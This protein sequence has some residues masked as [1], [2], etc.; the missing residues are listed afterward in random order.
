MSGEDTTPYYLETW[1]E[2]AFGLGCLAV[3][4]LIYQNLRPDWANIL[5][6][7][8]VEITSMAKLF[9]EGRMKDAF[10]NHNIPPVYPLLLAAI[11][12]IRHISELPRLLESLQILNLALCGISAALVHF[13]VRRQLPK[14]YNFII[15]GLYVLAPTTYDMAWPYTPHMTYMVMSMAALVAI[16]IS[17]SWDSVL[18]GQLSPREIAICGLFLVLSIL[19]WQ[20]GYLLLLAFMCVLLKRFGLK[21]SLQVTLGVMLCIAPFIARDLQAMSSDSERYTASTR[22]IIQ[23]V[24]E[25]GLVRTVGVYADHIMLK[26]ASTTIGDLN[27]SSLNLLGDSSHSA[28]A[29]EPSNY[30]EE[31]TWLRWV[32][33]LVAMVGAFYGFSYYTGVGAF[34][35]CIYVIASVALLPAS[36]LLLAPVIPLL[37]FYLYSGLLRTGAWMHR[38][39]LPLLTRIAIPVLTGWIVLCTLSSYLGRANEHHDQPSLGFSHIPKIMYMGAPPD[40]STRLGEA[41]TVTAHRKAMEWLKKNA[42]KAHVG[43]APPET[44]GLLSEELDQKGHQKGRQKNEPSARAAQK[45]ALADEL[46]QYDYLLEE[47]AASITHAK[48]PAN[49]N[50]KM[51]YE[52]IPGRTRIWKV[53]SS[54]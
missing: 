37:I 48:E 14:P 42:S 21:K 50:L 39:E 24:R 32:V 6:P 29:P 7:G 16:D 1:F 19:S 20:A 13:F 18:G 2:P 33:G 45:K 52:D 22:Q 54:L 34:Y 12:K 8:T 4:Y 10:F 35:M 23:S 41:Q 43:A 47:G 31:K 25:E 36:G 26:L 51:V 53:R 11:M 3:I 9:A 44:V 5:S 46:G 38:L 17:L 40:S 30:F 28:P 49:K 27:L 15:T